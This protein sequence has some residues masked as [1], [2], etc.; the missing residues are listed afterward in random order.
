MLHQPVCCVA[1]AQCP[2]LGAPAGACHP[3]ALGMPLPGVP[4]AETTTHLCALGSSFISFAAF[5][6][7]SDDP[8]HVPPNLVGASRA[9]GGT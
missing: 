4:M 9:G 7:R 6:M 5:R 1:Q 8:T 2:R 3:R